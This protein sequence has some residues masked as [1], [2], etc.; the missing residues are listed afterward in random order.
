MKIGPALQPSNPACSHRGSADE[1]EGVS[2][3]HDLIGTNENV[4][5]PDPETRGM[6]EL[7]RPREQLE[8]RVDVLEE[9]PAERGLITE[10]SRDVLRRHPARCGPKPNQ[11]AD[12]GEDDAY[13]IPL[14]SR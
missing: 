5:D 8:R 14:T 13:R 2:E 3:Q 12:R 9:R 11:Q 7:D 4:M 10:R 6:I 1:T